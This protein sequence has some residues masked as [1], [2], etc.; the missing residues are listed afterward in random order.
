MITRRQTLVLA[1]GI[2]LYSSSVAGQQVPAKGPRIGVISTTASTYPGYAAFREALSQLGYVDGQNIQIEARFAAGQLDQLANFAMEIVGLEVDLIAVIGAVTVRAVRK[3]TTT[4]P[5]VFTVVLDPVE[6]GLVPNAE[7]PGGNIT[8]ATNFDP[9]Q[10]R[11]QMRL[12]KQIVPGLARVAILGDAG[13]PNAVLD[14]ANWQAAEAEGLR[15]QSI[16]LRGAAE[17][18]DAVF[19]SITDERAGAVLGLEVPAVGLHA[20]RI[21]ALGTAARLPTM[22]AGDWFF[23]RP[24]L[25]YGSS[26]WAAARRMAGMVD[27]ILKGTR[28]GDLPIE[29]V[30]ERK[31]SINL[32]LAREIGLNIPP[33]VLVRA[34][35]VFD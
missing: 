3:E 28:P 14:R 20:K 22:F 12:L 7:H 9:A 32:R 34:D 2:G 16:R 15:P 30:T 33:E 29:V 1:S 25:A 23:H 6:D 18:L 10:P 31:L 17:D 13:V 24:T 27:R 26:L 5:T 8:G 11:A 21:I 19:A 4:I 35:E